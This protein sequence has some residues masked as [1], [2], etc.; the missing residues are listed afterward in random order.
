MGLG[1][2][3]GLGLG[4]GLGLGLGSGLG[5]GLRKRLA[6][7]LGGCGGLLAARLKVGNT[8]VAERALGWR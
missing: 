6:C 3:L 7:K 1:L 2:R 8:P 5:L 4:S